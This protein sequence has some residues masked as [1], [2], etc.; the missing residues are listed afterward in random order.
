MKIIKKYII[1]IVLFTFSFFYLISNKKFIVINKTSEPIRATNFQYARLNTEPTISEMKSYTYRYTVENNQS[2][3]LKVHRNNLL[4]KSLYISIDFFYKLAGPE[5]DKYYSLKGTT[6][7]S[8]PQYS[9]QSAYCSFQI[10]V[11]PN[12]KTT[13]TPTRKW[14]CI[15]PMYYHKSSLA[16]EE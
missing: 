14:G 3:V 6:F 12:S 2:R 7:S 1:I 16:D 10:E 13:V 11:Y 8:E 15:N 4:N 5:E 9:R